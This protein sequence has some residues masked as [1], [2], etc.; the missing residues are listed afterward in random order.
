MRWNYTFVH[1]WDGYWLV[2]IRLI[3]ATYL[4]SETTFIQCQYLSAHKKLWKKN[5]KP[6]S[7]SFIF[8]FFSHCI[9]RA[10]YGHYLLQAKHGTNYCKKKIIIS[11]L[12]N[13]ITKQSEFFFQI[14][15]MIS[16][17]LPLFWLLRSPESL[18]WP[19]FMGWRPSSCVVR[20]HLLPRNY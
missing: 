11:L 19:I 4:C 1:L 20:A 14:Y 12:Y 3:A 2:T 17:S 10:T 13:Y 15:L 7:L 8:N 6:L 9:E 18:R 16:F 5:I